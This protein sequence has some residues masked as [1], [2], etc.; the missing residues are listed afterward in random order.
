MILSS[1]RLFVMHKYI[2]LSLLLLISYAIHANGLCSASPHFSLKTFDEHL[3]SPNVRGTA[4]DE[5][6]LIRDSTPAPK[7]GLLKKLLQALQFRKNARAR[8]QVRVLNIIARSGLKDSLQASV[9][10]LDSMN[11][12]RRS[13]DI[14]LQQQ[15]MMAVLCAIDTLRMRI[16]S[17]TNA[18]DTSVI[19][20]ENTMPSSS[21]DVPVD[22]QEIQNLVN[23]V[24]T[25]VDK[26]QQAKLSLVR[27]LLFGQQPLLDTIKINDSISEVHGYKVHRTKEIIGFLPY[28]E[29]HA[30]IDAYLR[31]I[32]ELSWYAVGF[33]GATGSLT[34][35]NG[36]DTSPVLDSARARGCRI[37]L[38]IASRDQKNIAELL[39]DTT[40]QQKLAMNIVTALRHRHADGVQ[41]ALDSLPASSGTAFTFFIMRLAK[42][43]KMGGVTYNLGVRVPAFDPDGIYELQTLKNYADYLLLDFTQYRRAYPGPLAPLEGVRNDDMTTCIS[44]CLNMGIP[45]SQLIVCLPY[46]GVGWKSP[47]HR[48]FQGP[49]DPKTYELLRSDPIYQQ[50]LIWE[51]KSATERLDIRNKSKALIERVWFDDERSLAA[52]YDLIA[53]KELGGVA[54]QA[55]GDDEGYGELWDVLAYKFTSVDTIQDSIKRHRHKAPVLEDWQWSWAYIGAKL[56][57]YRIL[58]A[59]PCESKFPKVLI[60]KWEKDGVKNN[61]R[62]LIRKEAATVLG[63]LSLSLT[64]LFLGGVLLFISKL[65]KIGD[66][67]KWTKPLAA[68][69]IFLFIFLTITGFMYL[70]LDTSMVYFGVSDSPADCFDFPLGILFIVIFTGITIG[71][72]ITRFLV[73]PLIKRQDVP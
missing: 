4:H 72:L 35:L 41:L 26:Q 68:L 30:K 62:S 19:Y 36:W 46:Y 37:S 67:W 7:V 18:G 34:T 11:A 15:S 27:S 25:P 55:L 65:R 16:D 8:E 51:P 54:L 24:V 12:L 45:P 33:K 10:V 42:T 14:T 44:R 2:T 73:F 64:V 28:P 43:L 22:D 57:Q 52:K 71:V 32:T 63:R 47:D 1:G 9:H 29:A 31:L 40:A 17:M 13:S 70:F 49:P 5:Y 59:Y 39:K 20:E 60:R 58:L 38:C 3:I 56:E 61:D 53:A 21:V 69:L 66:G 6:V 50:P 48:T 23:Q